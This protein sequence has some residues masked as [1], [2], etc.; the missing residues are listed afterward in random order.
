[1][2]LTNIIVVT[3]PDYEI[4]F[5]HVT[6]EIRQRITDLRQKN[7]LRITDDESRIYITDAV[8]LDISATEIRQ[9]IRE[10]ETGWQELVPSEVAKYIKKYDLYIY[11]I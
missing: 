1:M 7:E 9:K 4:E 6:D 8:Q 10:N 11:R 2:T 5:S 3:R